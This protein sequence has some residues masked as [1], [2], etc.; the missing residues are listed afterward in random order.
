MISN[1]FNI[2]ELLNTTGGLL[3]HPSDGLSLLDSFNAELIII[4][5]ATLVEIF[6]LISSN[7]GLQS[8]L[9]VLSSS[10]EPRERIINYK[11]INLS[12]PWWV[13]Y[14]RSILLYNFCLRWLWVR[15]MLISICLY[16]SDQTTQDSGL[17]INN[18]LHTETL[19]SSQHS[20][21]IQLS[22]C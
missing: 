15:R 6:V 7:V 5:W 19:M 20:A 18:K 4:W 17:I 2:K 11:I 10:P 16:G 21:T 8:K 9:K 3:H 12:K 22:S 13:V 14:S 1:N